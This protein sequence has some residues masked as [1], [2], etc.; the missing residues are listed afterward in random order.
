[1]FSDVHPSK[2]IG[3][4]L[5]RGTQPPTSKALA[6][7]TSL[8]EWKTMIQEATREMSRNKAFSGSFSICIGGKLFF[9]SSSGEA[10]RGF[11]VPNRQETPFP[12]ASVTKLLTGEAI[13]LLVSD[14]KVQ[15]DSKISQ[16]FPEFKPETI[17]D[18]TVS[19]L[20]T[21]TSGIELDDIPAFNLLTPNSL[22]EAAKD[23]G[24]FLADTSFRPP[25]ELGKVYDY[26]N[27]NYVLLGRIIEIASKS[28]FYDFIDRNIL[29][30]VSM[31]TTYWSNALPA[32]VSEAKSYSKRRVDGTFL[33]Q[34]RNVRR[35]NFGMSS[36]AGGL[37]SNTIDM[38]RFAASFSRRAQ[39]QGIEVQK[40][41]AFFQSEDQFTQFGMQYRLVNG[42]W[43][44]GHSGALVG[45]SSELWVFP[46]SNI[47]FVILS[48][49]DSHA[50]NILGFLFETMPLAMFESESRD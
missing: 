49:H 7:A 25:A 42:A 1:M 27:E 6:R 23:I 3:I 39:N 20:L 11:H 17:A 10:D 22:T 15:L 8:S 40:I 34:T 33:P 19:H 28:N 5:D 43:A 26:S 30:K 12:I 35:S 36:P 38:Q 47:S 41:G 37:V 32:F 50:P 45:S 9:Q 29:S 14:G 4:G 18:I 44:M 2:V 16:F 46:K 21:H 31:K 13:R 48:N 24:K